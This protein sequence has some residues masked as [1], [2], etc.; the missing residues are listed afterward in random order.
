MALAP[1]EST[2]ETG[3]QSRTMEWTVLGDLRWTTSS[4]LVSVQLSPEGPFLCSSNKWL[5]DT[6]S[7]DTSWFLYYNQRNCIFM[8]GF[9]QVKEPQVSD[10]LC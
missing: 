9:Q 2:K 10:V 6:T 3:V 4:V 7:W 8:K 1:T 5:S